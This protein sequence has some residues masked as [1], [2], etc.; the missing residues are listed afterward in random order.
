[1]QSLL[2]FYYSYFFIPVCLHF[3]NTYIETRSSKSAKKA[4][5]KSMQNKSTQ[6]LLLWVLY[7]NNCT[8]LWPNYATNMSITSY[9][10]CTITTFSLNCRHIYTLHPIINRLTKFGSNSFILKSSAYTPPTHEFIFTFFDGITRQSVIK[11][12]LLWELLET[13]S[14]TSKLPPVPVYTCHYC[15]CVTKQHI[16]FL[17]KSPSNTPA[18]I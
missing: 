16:Y 5:D 3:K 1:M 15:W 14:E 2:F 9:I 12:Y 10:S 17:K 11:S 7:M 18:L 13:I 6:L 8:I 4:Q